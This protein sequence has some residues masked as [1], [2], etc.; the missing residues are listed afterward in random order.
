[1]GFE[2]EEVKETLNEWENLSA[3]KKNR[4][5]DEARLKGLRDQISNLRGYHK[6]GK[7]EGE[8]TFYF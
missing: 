5:E 3:D 1:M 6:L 2:F 4:V 8:G 7:E